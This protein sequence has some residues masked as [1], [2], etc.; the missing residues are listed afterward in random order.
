MAISSI[1]P[2]NSISV[3]LNKNKEFN[4]ENME[5]IKEA[6]SDNEADKKLSD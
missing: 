6:L 1:E 3:L 4:N 2:K 5:E